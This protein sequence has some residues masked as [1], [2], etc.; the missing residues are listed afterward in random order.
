MKRATVTTT[1]VASGVPR[2]ILLSPSV[3]ASEGAAEAP[4]RGRRTRGR[5][6]VWRR[7]T[8]VGEFPSQPLTSDGIV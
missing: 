5:G 2:S 8:A 7:L 1:M 6:T 4:G 3:A